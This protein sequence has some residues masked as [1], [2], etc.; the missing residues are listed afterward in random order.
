MQASQSLRTS[1]WLSTAVTALA[2]SAGGTPSDSTRI[3]ASAQ[4]TARA[5][6]TTIRSPTASRHNRLT[7]CALTRSRT[8]TTF[9]CERMS[10]GNRSTGDSPLAVL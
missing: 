1:R 5:E 3:N 9:G 8:T 7:V 10:L 2:N 4:S 6:V